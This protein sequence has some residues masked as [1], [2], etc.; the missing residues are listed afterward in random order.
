MRSSAHLTAVVAVIVGLS[1][2]LA[3]CPL[4]FQKEARN[5]SPPFTFFDVY[6]GREDFVTHEWIPVS[7][8]NQ[9][10]FHWVGTDL[11]SDVVAYQY[12]LVQTNFEYFVADTASA[13]VIRSIDPRRETADS[14]WTERV[15]SNFQAFS[16]LADG[17]YEMR[18]RSIDAQGTASNIATF[19][20]EIYFDDVPPQVSIVSPPG[21][22]RAPCGRISPQTSWTFFFA[23][24]DSSR[25]GETPRDSLEY[26]YRLRANSTV[27]CNTHTSDQF[28]PWTHF[29][30]DTV[31]VG[32]QPPTLYSDLTDPD[33]GWDFTVRV[34][35][36][37]GNIASATCCVAWTRGCQ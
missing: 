27:D 37:A 30:A 17:W 32:G 29:V 6:P 25:S 5:D 19:R 9:V 24:L 23:A 14:L 8:Q 34:R 33:C 12:Q 16:G 2:L 20:F 7:Y 15:T 26:S 21:S 11:D 3:G 28:E 36:P 35:D 18:A 1:A 10:S 4:E 13:K 22:P 31:Q